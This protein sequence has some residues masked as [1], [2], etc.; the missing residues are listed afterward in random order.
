LR[1]AHSDRVYYILDNVITAGFPR[2]ILSILSHLWTGHRKRHLM[3]FRE[4]KVA[5]AAAAAAAAPGSVG[6]S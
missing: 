3:T 2:K 6:Y 1:I 4:L 5:A